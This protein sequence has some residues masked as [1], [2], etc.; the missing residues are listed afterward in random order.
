MLALLNYLIEVRNTN[1][2][3]RCPF[4][5]DSD[6][7]NHIKNNLTL[8]LNYYYVYKSGNETNGKFI[9]APNAE[10]AIEKANVR[11]YITFD[12]ANMIYSISGKED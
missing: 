11:S 8:D 9:I 5:S 12:S 3:D 4:I 2:Y 10:S 6:L 7:D 1:S